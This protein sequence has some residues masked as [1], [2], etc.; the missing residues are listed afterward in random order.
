MLE[1][2]FSFT[3][4]TGGEG[5]SPEYNEKFL[6]SEA[7]ISF[8]RSEKEMKFRNTFSSCMMRRIKKCHRGGFSG[9]DTNPVFLNAAKTALTIFLKFCTP[10][11][12]DPIFLMKKF[13]DP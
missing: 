13:L 7:S 9:F 1:R 6:A 8:E 11:Y 10:P 3:A 12:F 4:R 5:R 2:N